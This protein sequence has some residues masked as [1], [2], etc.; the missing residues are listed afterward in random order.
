MMPLS[1]TRALS[2][3]CL[4]AFL[5]G[6]LRAQGGSPVIFDGGVS[7]RNAVAFSFVANDPAIA[8]R[9]VVIRNA[10]VEISGPNALRS[11]VLENSRLSPSLQQPLDLSIQFDLTMDAVSSLDATGRGH[12]FGA[13]PG[14]GQTSGNLNGAGSGAGHGGPGGGCPQSTGGCSG[15]APV[16]GA[17]YGSVMNPV[18]MGSGGGSSGNTRS[19]GGSGGGAIRISV[20]GRFLVDGVIEADGV[21]GLNESGVFINRGGGGAGGSIWVT[22]GAFE[23]SGG[24]RAAGGSGSAAGGGGG[25][26]AIESSSS[27]FV[28]QMSTA[29]GIGPDTFRNGGAGTIWTRIAGAPGTL[30]IDNRGRL[31]DHE[32]PLSGIA[33]C[34][35]L[36]V[37]GGAMLV[38][39]GRFDAE[40]VIVG[41]AGLITHEPLDAGGVE[42]VVSGDMEVQRG[43]A[44]DVDRKGYPSDQGPG[45][46]LQ[47]LGG[48]SHGGQGASP[49]RAPYG[50]AQ[51]PTTLG[52]GGGRQAGWGFLLGGTGGG[53]IRLDVG[54]RLTV[55]G[56]ISANGGGPDYFSLLGAIGGQGAGG[57]V[58]IT[59]DEIAGRGV[60]RA[61]GG[62][63][64][65]P[66]SNGGGGGRVAVHAN[67]WQFPTDRVHARGRAGTQGGNP[68]Q[69]GTVVMPLRASRSRVSVIDGGTVEFAIDVGAGYAFQPYLL[70]PS[71]SGTTPGT[72]L[73]GGALLPLNLDALTMWAIDNANTPPYAMNLGILDAQGRASASVTIPAGALAAGSSLT[74]DHAFAAGSGAPSTPFVAGGPASLELEGGLAV[75]G[76]WDVSMDD[77]CV[78]AFEAGP[79]TQRL[80]THPSYLLFGQ[81]GGSG[82]AFGSYIALNGPAGARVSEL[83]IPLVF[84]SF[85]GPTAGFGIETTECGPRFMQNHGL[86]SLRLWN[87]PPSPSNPLGSTASLSLAPNEVALE[88]PIGIVDQTPAYGSSTVKAAVWVL[89]LDLSSQPINIPQ[90]GTAFVTLDWGWDF[91]A[92][93]GPGLLAGMSAT[94]APDTLFDGAQVVSIDAFWSGVTQWATTAIQR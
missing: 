90:S 63:P 54:G 29:G 8:G 73:P 39:S 43:G 45:A 80:V 52:S 68:G 27:T 93:P 34:G 71:L 10:W 66:T 94:P 81:Q 62:A 18:T 14:A 44:I 38:L 83:K 49:S 87:S 6:V 67:N 21:P 32:T 56:M 19:N 15:S 23:G 78:D 61:D 25:R 42:L 11:L 40:Q 33:A 89:C 3:L 1:M 13:G 65:T 16:G 51:Q 24:V 53:V 4:L 64:V 92:S 31:A 22:C 20:G 36:Q 72:P 26:I 88:G 69:S 84:A 30:I 57:S 77:F 60:I 82:F 76:G 75:R 59:A 70:A 74:I 2:C 28:G 5:G 46:G 86:P 37:T 7:G 79:T 17:A 47:S 58:W 12:P 50:N 9:D 41:P 48:G 55:D 35:T 85:F 91:S